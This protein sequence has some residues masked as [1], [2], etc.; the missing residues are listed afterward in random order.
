M[1]PHVEV[2]IKLHDRCLSL[3]LSRAPIGPSGVTGSYIQPDSR[4]VLSPLTQG[5]SYRGTKGVRSCAT[6]GE[7]FLLF[8]SHC[9]PQ[10]PF[11][12]YSYIHWKSN[13]FHLEAT[14]RS[15]PSKDVETLLK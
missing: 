6:L 9:Y 2:V 5:M 1:L 11:Q 15:T 14:P 4:E 13:I 7:L 3:F 12:L 8:S 10:A